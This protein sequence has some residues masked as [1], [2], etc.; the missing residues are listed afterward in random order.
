[1]PTLQETSIFHLINKYVADD[2]EFRLAKMCLE[3]DFQQTQEGTCEI[4][5]FL[6]SWMKSWRDA[7]K[8]SSWEDV[9][10]C[11]NITHPEFRGQYLFSSTALNFLAEMLL[12]KNMDQLER[13]GD[14]RFR[15]TGAFDMS[16]VDV[17]LRES[18]DIL[19]SFKDA[20]LFDVDVSWYKQFVQHSE[21]LQPHH[22]LHQ[23]RQSDQLEEYRNKFLQ[24]KSL[25]ESVN[26]TNGLVENLLNAS[27]RESS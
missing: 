23:T 10:K 17:C 22:H 21:L 27:H 26:N 2:G 13:L 1:M 7:C 12:E 11:L 24:L 14:R 3:I 20:T 4:P 19:N 16:Q 18:M 25:H 15:C 9:K 5:Q 6:P 8:C